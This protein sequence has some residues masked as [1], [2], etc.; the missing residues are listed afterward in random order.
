MVPFDRPI[1]AS[2]H[3]RIMYG[4]I[5]PEGSVAKITGK[6]GEKF[7]GPARFLMASLTQ[8]NQ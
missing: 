5:A 4:N 7:E 6:E 2:G 3:L 8:S 1:K